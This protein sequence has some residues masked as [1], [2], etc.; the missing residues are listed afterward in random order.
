MKLSVKGV[1]ILLLIQVLVACTKAEPEHAWLSGDEHQR[2]ATVAEHL[3]GNDLVM[4]EVRYRHNELYE[5]IV[6]GN[7]ELAIYQLRKMEVAMIKGM[8]RRPKRRASY[9][10]F[11]QTA[12][13]AMHNSLKNAEGLDG[14]KTFTSQCVQ[15]HSMENVGFMPVDT[16][17][18]E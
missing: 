17:W 5:A 3:R 12:I 8:E 10:W 14:Y 16:P 9:E 7:S 4:W 18:Q 15:C 6:S 2:I 11:F 13:P 1:I